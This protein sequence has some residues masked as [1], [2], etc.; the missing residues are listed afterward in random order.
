MPRN[1]I[2]QSPP[3]SRRRRV[4]VRLNGKEYRVVTDTDP[5]WLQ[6]VADKVEAAMAHGPAFTRRTSRNTV[7]VSSRAA[8][9]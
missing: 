6:D 4:T 7:R 3:P 5:D 9:T 1:P 8:T 2:V